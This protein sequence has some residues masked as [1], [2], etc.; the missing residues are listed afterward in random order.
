MLF[1]TTR[2]THTCSYV[3]TTKEWEKSQR[4]KR[5][6]CSKKHRLVAI[7]IASKITF[8]SDWMCECDFQG[9]MLKSCTCINVHFTLDG[10]VHW[11]Q[12]LWLWE[13]RQPVSVC[14][15]SKRWARREWVFTERRSK[16][17]SELFVSLEIRHQ[18]SAFQSI[19]RVY[20]RHSFTYNKKFPL[21]S[22]LSLAV[23]CPPLFLFSKHSCTHSLLL[24]NCT[25]FIH[26]VKCKLF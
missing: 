20:V 7:A 6:S 2:I 3:W 14:K 24:Y 15:H 17:A 8:H 18:L 1:D 25:K 16:K 5:A 4:R 21:N 26:A 10:N 19:S 23:A 11:S 12:P 9:E 13:E 22:S